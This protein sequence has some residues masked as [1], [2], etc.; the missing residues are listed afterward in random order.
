VLRKLTTE[1]T[2]F[3]DEITF[4]IQE[5]VKRQIDSMRS[6]EDKED[7]NFSDADYLVAIIT[8]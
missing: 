3:T 5:E 7:P 6:L 8:S 2:A 1:A 4:E